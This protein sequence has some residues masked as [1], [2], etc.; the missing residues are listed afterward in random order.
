MLFGGAV[1]ST[2]YFFRKKVDVDGGT[3]F[4]EKGGD[5]LKDEPKAN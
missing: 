2:F 4:K 5:V 3:G 1:K